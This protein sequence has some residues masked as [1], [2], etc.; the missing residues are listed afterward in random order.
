VSEAVTAAVHHAYRELLAAR[1]GAAR[2]DT[3]RA[4]AAP[5]VRRDARIAM[6]GN[7]FALPVV[8]AEG[9]GSDARAFY[10]GSA[11]SQSRAGAVSRPG[12]Q[13]GRGTAVPPSN[14]SRGLGAARHVAR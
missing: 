10:A 5:T 13:N 7:H 3:E 12:S 8:R 4:G 14:R 2:H 11:T 9:L 1:R 6:S